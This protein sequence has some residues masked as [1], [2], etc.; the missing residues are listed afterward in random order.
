MSGHPESNGDARIDWKLRISRLC[1]WAI[2]NWPTTA[3]NHSVMSVLGL[4]LVSSQ[5]K[6]NFGVLGLGLAAQV[7]GLGF[8]SQVLGLGLGLES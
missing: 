7:I 4:I 3:Q 2:Q 1:T 8:E 5:V 6:D